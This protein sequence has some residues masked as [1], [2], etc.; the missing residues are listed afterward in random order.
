MPVRRFTTARWLFS[1]RVTTARSRS[2][3]ST[4]SGSG[5]S[6]AT[7]ARPVRSTSRSVQSRTVPVEVEDLEQATGRLRDEA[8]VLVL[9]TLVLDDDGGVLAARA[10]PPPSQAAR[11]A[12]WL[13]TTARLAQVDHEQLPRGRVELVER[14]VAVRVLAGARPRRARRPTTATLVGS[15]GRSR[16]PSGC[17]SPRDPMVSMKPSRPVKASV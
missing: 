7:S 15:P 16:D 6:G 9:V 13:R 5:S 14:S 8:V 10:T 3:T 2:L 17:G 4:Y 11:R 1:W 12:R